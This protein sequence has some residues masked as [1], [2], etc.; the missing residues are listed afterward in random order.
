MQTLR[1]ALMRTAPDYVWRMK[2][3]NPGATT[4]MM[5]PLDYGDPNACSEKRDMRSIATPTRN[6]TSG[7]AVAARNGAPWQYGDG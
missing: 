3:L 2:S 5:H 4:I 6:G 7:R 1:F